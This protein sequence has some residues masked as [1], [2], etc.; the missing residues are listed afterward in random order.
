[1]KN[2]LLYP[3]LLILGLSNLQTYSQ[4]TWQGPV[5]TVKQSSYHDLYLSPEVTCRLAPEGGNIRIYGSNQLEVPY[6]LSSSNHVDQT[7][8]LK[9]YRRAGERY[10]RRWYSRSL[11][12][13]PKKNPID[14]MV[15]KVKNADV[16]QRFWLSGSDDM[17]HWYIIKEDYVYDAA[18]DPSSTY[19]LLTLKFP[20]VDYRYYKVELKH[21]WREP[22]NIMGAGF[23]DVQETGGHYQQIKGLTITQSNDTLG[24]KSYVEVDLGQN[25]YLDRIHFT[26]DGPEMYH[27]STTLE[28]IQGDG[29]R[30]TLSLNSNTVSQI[31]FDHLRARK[32]RLTINNKDDQPIR[33]AGVKA[34]Q[35]KRTL[36]AKLDKDKNYRLEIGDEGQSA[37]EYDLVHFQRQIPR[38][39]PQLAIDSTVWI[40][41]PVETAE[42]EVVEIPFETEIGL[43][44]EEAV[45]AATTKI[46]EAS[47]FTSKT[48]LWLGIGV[49]LVA[50]TWFSIALLKDKTEEEGSGS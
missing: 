1:M 33:I 26:V 18:Y 44:N 23:Y 15:L 13:N 47:F 19:N 6:L 25:H 45:T 22:I 49:I 27:R 43:P 3:F 21:I 39:R 30:K 17:T 37:P 20:T 42:G 8:D 9:W 29:Y 10:R 46:K 48:F 32:L 38:N 12:E 40:P 36:T 24:K 14:E 35:L 5:P 16:S 41:D 28:V 11:F 7:V 34:Y 2:F 50:M 4:G 31:Q